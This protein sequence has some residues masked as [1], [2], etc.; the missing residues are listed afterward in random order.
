[1]ADF[2]CLPGCTSCRASP[3]WHMSRAVARAR[4]GRGHAGEKTSLSPAGASATGRRHNGRRA[5][6]SATCPR[7][8]RGERVRRRGGHAC[9]RQGGDVYVRQRAAGTPP[10][11][12]TTTR[13]GGGEGEWRRKNPQRHLQTRARL[14]RGRTAREAVRRAREVG[15]AGFWNLMRYSRGFWSSCGHSASVGGWGGCALVG[16]YGADGGAGNSADRLRTAGPERSTFGNCALCRPFPRS[17]SWGA[18]PSSPQRLSS[19][20]LDLRG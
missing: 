6:A 2:Q 3:K 19:P 1:M 12:R 20:Q 8:R 18:R 7:P 16:P 4:T 14:D 17:P 9:T 13:A 5:G 15:V 11:A 10:G